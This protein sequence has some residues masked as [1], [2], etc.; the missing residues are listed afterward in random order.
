MLCILS[1]CLF[2]LIVMFCIIIVMSV[3][4]Y[5]CVH[6][7][8]SICLFMYL[9]ILVICVMLCYTYC[10][11]YIFLSLFL[12]ILIVLHS[13]SNVYVFLLLCILTVVF[14]YSYCYVLYVTFCVFCFIVSFCVLFVCKCVLHCCHR[15]STQLQLTNI[16][17]HIHI[18]YHIILYH[19]ILERRS[20]IQ[21]FAQP[22]VTGSHK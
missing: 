12:Y 2:V 20:T 9:C 8:I 4:S 19:P 17:Y 5:C 21:T 11:V 6:V 16:E 13:Y 15:V 22:A 7:F 1:L 14:M 3:Y 18:I 10:N